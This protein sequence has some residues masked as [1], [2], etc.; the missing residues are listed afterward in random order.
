MKGLLKPVPEEETPVK[1]TFAIVLLLIVELIPADRP[2][3]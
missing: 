3:K 2:L 1:L